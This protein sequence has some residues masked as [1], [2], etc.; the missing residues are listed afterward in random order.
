M[1]SAICIQESWLSE[2]EDTSQI[3]LEDCKCITQGKSFSS[4][5]GLIIYLN[6]WYDYIPKLKFNT[7]NTWEGQFIQVKKGETL[8]KPINIGNIYR[9]PKKYLEHYN[10]FMNEFSPI[11]NS[12]E[13]N[14][15]EVIITVDSI[16]D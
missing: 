8:S 16:R 4:K 5:G 1:F 2:N 3:E 15:N 10:E 14:N 12:M 7:Y 11:L 13:A 6:K 9:P